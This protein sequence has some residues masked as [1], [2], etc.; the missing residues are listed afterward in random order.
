MESGPFNPVCKYA[1][2]M[3]FF[4]T[5]ESQLTEITGHALYYCELNSAV[6][7]DGAQPERFH[8]GNAQRVCDDIRNNYHH[9]NS[10]LSPPWP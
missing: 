3:P 9:W 7:Q 10:A 2:R 8:A 5:T 6:L 4:T 1:N